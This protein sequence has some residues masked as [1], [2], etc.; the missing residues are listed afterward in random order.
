MLSGDL[1]S[2]IVKMKVMLLVTD[3]VFSVGSLRSMQGRGAAQDLHVLAHFHFH[4]EIQLGSFTFRSLTKYFK[5]SF[6]RDIFHNI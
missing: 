1:C 6:S 4:S 2:N 3:R 5:S